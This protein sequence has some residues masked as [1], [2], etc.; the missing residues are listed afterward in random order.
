MYV[1]FLIFI[2]GK[3]VRWKMFQNVQLYFFIQETNIY[4]PPLSLLFHTQFSIPLN[5]YIVNLFINYL[6]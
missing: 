4:L 2:V 3:S 6:Y 1:T 5:I